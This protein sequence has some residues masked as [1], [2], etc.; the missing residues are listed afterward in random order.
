MSFRELRV[1]VDA[2]R[3]AIDDEQAQLLQAMTTAL[4][5]STTPTM[6]DVIDG[7][8]ALQTSRLA[9]RSDMEALEKLRRKVN[10]KR[11]SD[12]RTRGNSR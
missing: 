1:A 3:K 7:F 2:R 4:T 10:C 9:L 5:D 8:H 12:G 11:G 6:K